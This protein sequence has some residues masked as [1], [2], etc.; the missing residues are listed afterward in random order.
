MAHCLEAAQRLSGIGVCVRVVEMYTLKPLDW[1]LVARCAA[2]TGAPMTVEEHSVIGGL[3]GA[4]AEV[5]AA[6]Q[7]V[8][9]ERLGVDDTF[10]ETG[11]YGELLDRYGLSVDAIVSATQRAVARKSS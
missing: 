10:A 7:P 5:L 3:E 6:R 8:A 9:L 11:P 1:E 2:E 4:V